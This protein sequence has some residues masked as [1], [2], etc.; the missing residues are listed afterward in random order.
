MNVR[1]GL[2]A[3]LTGITWFV[4]NLVCILNCPLERYLC[5]AEAL[6]GL[7]YQ[8]PTITLNI[9]IYEVLVGHTKRQ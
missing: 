9:I 4:N 6:K 8:L 2:I 3:F 5:L 7:Q 1:I